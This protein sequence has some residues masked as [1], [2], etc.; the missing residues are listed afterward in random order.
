MVE[1]ESEFLELCNVVLMTP[2]KDIQRCELYHS[3]LGLQDTSSK[4]NG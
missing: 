2:G 1:Q 4:Y 3:P